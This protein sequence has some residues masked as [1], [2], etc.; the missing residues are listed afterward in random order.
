MFLFAFVII[1]IMTTTI[2]PTKDLDFQTLNDNI[3][4]MDIYHDFKKTLS[5]YM[6]I[7]EV[8]KSHNRGKTYLWAGNVNEANVVLTKGIHLLE[9]IDQYGAKP[10]NKISR[11]NNELTISD[12]VDVLHS[13]ARVSLA[14]SQLLEKPVDSI[15][16]YLGRADHIVQG[17]ISRI[18]SAFGSSRS[19]ALET[20][21]NP[22]NAKLDTSRALRVQYNSLPR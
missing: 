18:E 3:S 17:V 10:D 11:A 21:V 13:M 9:I 7:V 12:A 6:S 22:W 20:L 16:D 19:S 5:K 2:T 4:G 14:K 1:F 8:D 15:T